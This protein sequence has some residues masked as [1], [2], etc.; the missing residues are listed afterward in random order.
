MLP[1]PPILAS[2]IH[3][4][5]QYIATIWIEILICYLLPPIGCIDR[6]EGL[7]MLAMRTVM[8]ASAPQAHPVQRLATGR[9][10]FLKAAIDF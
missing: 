6:D 1:K 4:A 5:I 10:G 2:P 8:G 9:A 3:K 7:L